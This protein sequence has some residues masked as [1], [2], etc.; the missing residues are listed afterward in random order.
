MRTGAAAR[1][2]SLVRLL[3]LSPFFPPT[4]HHLKKGL[5][6]QVPRDYCESRRVT[7]ERVL[8]GLL[9]INLSNLSYPSGEYLRIPLTGTIYPFTTK[10]APTQ[11]LQSQAEHRSA[12]PSSSSTTCFTFFSHEHPLHLSSSSLFSFYRSSFF[13]PFSFYLLYPFPHS[14]FLS[15]S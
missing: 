12:L 3:I 9:K 14:S 10:P 15:F 4:I 7:P 5:T 8:L 13:L 11:T 6:F 1:S 2:L